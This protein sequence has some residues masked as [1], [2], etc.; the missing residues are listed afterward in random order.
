MAAF[1][2]FFLPLIELRP[3]RLASGIGFS[4]LELQGDYSYLVLF[5]LSL[6]PFAIAYRTDVGGRGWQLAILGNLMLVFSFILPER[7]GQLI[8]TDAVTYLSDDVIINNPRILPSGGMFFGIFGGYMVLFGGLQDLRRADVARWGRLAIGWIGVLFIVFTFATGGL[9][10]Y[11]FMVELRNNGER[12]QEVTIQHITFVS[13]SLLIGFFVGIGL[14]LWAARSE[15]VAP[16]ILYSVGIIQTVPSLALFGLLLAPLA[17]F[18]ARLFS[19]IALQFIVFL[20]ITIAYG[21][22]FSS[23]QNRVPSMART[24]LVIIGALIAAIPLTLFV[25]VVVAFLYQIVLLRFTSDRFFD[26]NTLALL[27]FFAAFLVTLVR[28]FLPDE[29][30]RTRILFRLNSGLIVF[31]VLFVVFLLFESARVY[32]GGNVNL[33]TLSLSDLGISGIGVAPALIALTL[34]S[35]LPLVRNTYA[36]LN[37]VDPAIIDSGRGMGMTPRQI[38]LKIELPLAFPIVMAGVRNAGVALVG[39]GTIAQI[40]GG[41]GLGVFILRGINDT[42]IDLILL[43]LIPAVFLALA[44]DA[45]LR[46][47]EGVLVSPGIRQAEDA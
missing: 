21:A 25:A 33:D 18:G 32:L 35:L 5:F 22:L 1:A 9:E 29:P 38:F 6:I 30:V 11:S 41:G 27:I 47:I 42:S 44:L 20:V 39:I 10:N 23:I 17:V 46:F 26:G 28:R 43:G 8:L 4:L 31:G 12:L 24:P 7:A 13:V 40:I 3:N 19:D 45:S 34:Y 15:R 2:F 36:G 14:G 37:N 16:L